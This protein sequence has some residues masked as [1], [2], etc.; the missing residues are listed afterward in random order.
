MAGPTNPEWDL[1]IA[2]ASEDKDEF[3]RPLAGR[4]EELGASVWYDEFQLKPGDSLISTIDRGLASGQR[5]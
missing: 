5:H 4:L 1:F 3:V 2:H